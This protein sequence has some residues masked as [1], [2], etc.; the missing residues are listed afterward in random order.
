MD[1]SAASQLVTMME[2]VVEDDLEPLVPRRCPATAWSVK[3]GTAETII[4]GASGLVSRLPALFPRMPR[5]KIAVVLYNPEGGVGL[6]WIPRRR[7]LRHC[8]TA[9]GNWVSPPP[10]RPQLTDDAVS[11][12]E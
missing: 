7:F 6:I 8:A 9:V 2:S 12:K 4:D 5:L 10:R 1:A 3:T 11:L